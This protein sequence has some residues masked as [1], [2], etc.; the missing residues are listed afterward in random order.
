MTHPALLSLVTTVP[1]NQHQQ[2]EMHDRWLL[3]YINS[4]RAR[5]IFA[6]ADI[7][8]RYSVLAD[9]TFLADEPGSKARN[10]FYLHHARPLATQAIKQAL[11]QARLAATDIDHLIV[12]SCT[13]FDT[14]GL[15]VML[16]GDLGMRP[17]LRRSA[18]I[19]MGCYAGLTGLDRAMSE[20]AARPESRALILAL[21]LTTLHFQRGAKLENMIASAL[22]GDGVAATIIGPASPQASQL[23][24]LKTMTYTAYDTQDLMGLHL[25]DQGYQIHL[26]IQAPKVLR[27]IIPDLVIGFLDNSNLKISDIRF[28]GIHP[29]GPKIVDYMGQALQLQ[30]EALRYS[31]QVL[32]RYGN[33][34]SATIFFVL[35]EIRQQGHPQPGDYTLLL[36]FGPGLT[37]E[38]C[39][40]QWSYDQT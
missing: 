33:M 6:A 8:T 26:A 34:S 28:W 7:E 10:D 20:L 27:A 29:G 16:A 22:F 9:T 36:A 11:T 37:I 38:L 17:N 1:K 13:G 14:P 25:S 3:P 5:A 21:E 4:P 2:M 31:R 30:P 40:A 19:G 35:D 12:I 32:R 15:D 18:L 39:L 23:Q 24:L